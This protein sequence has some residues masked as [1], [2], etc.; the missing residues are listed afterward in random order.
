MLFS[1]IFLPMLGT[2]SA[3]EIKSNKLSGTAHFFSDIMKVHLEDE[4]SKMNAADEIIKTSTENEARGSEEVITFNLDSTASPS[5]KLKKD[6]KEI[7]SPSAGASLNSIVELI[8]QLSYSWPQPAVEKIDAD[9]IKSKKILTGNEVKEV[10]LKT[11]Y[12]SGLIDFQQFL[13]DKNNISGETN[14]K[15]INE[16]IASLN[17]KGKATI[18]ILKDNSE[19][20]ITLTKC[21]V[22]SSPDLTDYVIFDNNSEINQEPTSNENQFNGSDVNIFQNKDLGARHLTSPDITLQGDAASGTGMAEDLKTYITGQEGKLESSIAK[23]I[24]PRAE[25]AVI[26]PDGKSDLSG[27]ESILPEE[28]NVK[29]A[30]KTY[31]RINP[32]NYFEVRQ[33]IIPK[34]DNTRSENVYQSESQTQSNN[35]IFKG[36]TAFQIDQRPSSDTTEIFFSADKKNYQSGQMKAPDFIDTDP[37]ERF[38]KSTGFFPDYFVRKSDE[39]ISREIS[40][41]DEKSYQGGNFLRHSAGV[42]NS[43]VEPADE[44]SPKK[45]ISGFAEYTNTE[46][47]ISAATISEGSVNESTGEKE[48]ISEK[49][50]SIPAE[51]KEKIIEKQISDIPLAD[52]MEGKDSD[53]SGTEHESEEVQKHSTSPEIKGNNTL[54]KITT[55]KNQINT[56]IQEEIKSPAKVNPI[57]RGSQIRMPGNLIEPLVV[58]QNPGETN[59]AVPQKKNSK[60]EE[61][62]KEE[63]GNHTIHAGRDIVG[64]EPE[65]I[66]RFSDD[67]NPSEDKQGSKSHNSEL[68]NAIPGKMLQNNPVNSQAQ[69]NKTLTDLRE[70]IKNIHYKNIINEISNLAEKRENKEVLLKITPDDLG[71][72]KIKMNLSG[73]QVNVNVEVENEIVKNLVHSNSTV[74]RQAFIN[75]G[76]QL[77]SLNISLSQSEQKPSKSLTSKRKSSYEAEIKGVHQIESLSAPRRMGYNTYEF[78]V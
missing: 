30:I 64:N 46:Q 73:N 63:K 12:L 2:T 10:L 44:Q 43:A 58:S 65:N 17:K 39:D 27:K 21:N 28:I 25:D 29:S 51:K 22:A 15:A 31:L 50:L 9:P 16:L 49:N 36:H 48:V 71:K 5:Q 78:L 1:P 14:L 70:S 77:N 56:V 53:L 62:N 69:V 19:L 60:N 40:T 47:H 42:I 55:V 45:Y 6:S 32:E 74:L 11:A 41:K 23:N 13:S 54:S 76:L 72:V 20:K 59:G 8:N 26:K 67:N 57:M 52:K 38:K 7:T 24:S 37:G 35:R 66:S 3:D 34:T 33:V 68:N 18:K 61:V 75:N 4:N